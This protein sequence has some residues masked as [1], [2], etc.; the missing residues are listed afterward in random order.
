MRCVGKVGSPETRGSQPQI[1][2]TQQ[3]ESLLS[4]ESSNGVTDTTKL[5]YSNNN[6]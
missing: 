2:L 1:L 3:S 6:K 4:A 5:K